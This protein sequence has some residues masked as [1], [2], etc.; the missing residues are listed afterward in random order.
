MILFCVRLSQPRF[1]AEYD[2]FAGS[3]GRREQR[4]IDSLDAFCD[5][6]N[7]FPEV[8]QVSD[9][10][11]DKDDTFILCLFCALCT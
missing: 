5:F 2:G 10:F 9:R 3:R 7:F 8:A 6:L 11:V 4:S 1:M